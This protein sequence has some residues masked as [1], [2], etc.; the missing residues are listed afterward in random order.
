MGRI[1]GITVQNKKL[2]QN[3]KACIKW[4]YKNAKKGH[5]EEIDVVP[6]VLEPSWEEPNIALGLA[7]PQVVRLAGG[8]CSHF[9]C[10]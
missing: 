4:A 1:L 5:L 9:S 3:T 6:A 10:A 7:H 8:R 2:F